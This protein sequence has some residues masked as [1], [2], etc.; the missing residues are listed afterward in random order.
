MLRVYRRHNPVKCEHTER[1]WRRCSCPLW[2][3]G[4]L[5]GKRHHKTLKTR[6]WDEAQRKAQKLEAEGKPEGQPKTI[7]ETTEAFIRDAEARDLR[8]PSIYKYRL[9][10][11]QL[12]QF[13]ANKGLRYITECDV[14]NLRGFRES[15]TNENIG[16]RKK[17]ENLRTFFRF[18]HESG[19]LPSNPAKLIKPPKTDDP[20]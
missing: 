5:Q 8:E 6:N 4:T 14:E 3:D 13:A 19:W 9:L 11:K 10:F 16:A 1:T 7:T 15:W 18:V 17:L 12:N 20:P 2:V